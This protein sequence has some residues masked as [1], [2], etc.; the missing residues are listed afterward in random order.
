[1]RIKTKT[2]AYVAVVAALYAAIT[3]STVFMAYSPLQFRIAEA[4]NLLVFFNP[5]FA[6]AVLLGVLIANFFSPYGFVDV[7]FG[8]SASAIAIA[9]ILATRKVLGGGAVSLFV[10]AWWPVIVNALMIPLVFMLYGGEGVSLEAFLPFAGSIAFGQ[11]VVVVLFGYIF[12]RILMAKHPNFIEII[13]N[14]NKNAER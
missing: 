4:L 1:M 10:A 5:I 3:I 9:L 8:T 13:K 2:M 6:P 14:L 7:I 11:F 12:C